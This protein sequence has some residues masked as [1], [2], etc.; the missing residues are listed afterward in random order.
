M[1]W[2]QFQ[3]EYASK[4]GSKPST[5]RQ[6]GTP[7]KV[8]VKGFTAGKLTKENSKDM[9]NLTHIYGESGGYKTAQTGGQISFGGHAKA[10][11]QGKRLSQFAEHS[12]HE[13]HMLSVAK[14]RAT[15][16]RSFT[17]KIHNLMTTPEPME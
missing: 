17:E 6:T 11:E 15:V 7:R 14:K 10:V 2:E 16:M 1:T 9:E 13:S 4:A 12:K 8:E 3:E 5:P